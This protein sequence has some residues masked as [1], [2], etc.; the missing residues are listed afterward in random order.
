M[1]PSHNLLGEVS[2]DSISNEKRP[3]PGHL[4]PKWFK[5]VFGNNQGD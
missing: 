4:I 1:V 5:W 2:Q 3:N